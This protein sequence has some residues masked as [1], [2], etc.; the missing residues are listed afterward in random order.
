M[1]ATRVPT[2]VFRSADLD[3]GSGRRDEEEAGMGRRGE[4]RRDGEWEDERCFLSR[5]IITNA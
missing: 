5:Y 1:I 2:D 3:T 4:E